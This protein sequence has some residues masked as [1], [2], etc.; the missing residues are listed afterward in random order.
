M[1]RCVL[2]DKF[3]FH[4]PEHLGAYIGTRDRVYE[5]QFSKF[6]ALPREDDKA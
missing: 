2:D 6:M 4:G 1:T 5:D 3:V